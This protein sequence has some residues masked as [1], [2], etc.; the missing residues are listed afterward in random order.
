M[1][2]QDQCQPVRE[3]ANSKPTLC[4]IFGQCFCK[5]DGLEAVNFHRRFVFFLR[6]FFTP[7]QRRKGR[8]DTPEVEAHRKEKQANRALLVQGFLVFCLQ[9][10]MSVKGEELDDDSA[11][12]AVAKRCALGSRCQQWPNVTLRSWMCSGLLL[13]S[14]GVVGQTTAG[15]DLIRLD[16]P[17]IPEF[18]PDLCVFRMLSLDVEWRCKVY[19]VVSDSS[20]MAADQMVPNHVLVRELLGRP[21]ADA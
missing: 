16:V 21:L 12:G 11:W 20:A 2:F 4:Q 19:A 8:I 1:V 3:P 17:D 10:P 9:V 6:P 5:G 7:P 14:A 18:E 15:E 13:H